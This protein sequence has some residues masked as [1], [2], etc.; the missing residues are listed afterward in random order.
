MSTGGRQIE[1]L[2]P[3]LQVVRAVLESN[4]WSLSGVQKTTSYEYEGPWE[5]QT[6]RSAYAFFHRVGTPEEGPSIEVFIDESD[7]GV[8]GALSLVVEGPA[9]ERESDVRAVLVGAVETAGEA[10]PS[11][12][13]APVSISYGHPGRRPPEAARVKVR[14]KAKLP[15]PAVKGGERTVRATLATILEAFEHVLD[16]RSDAGKDPTKE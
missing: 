2:E 12:L 15:R 9:V 13:P 8:D 4:R 6:L 10:L 16:V 3:L 7:E 14:F 1:T 11:E 5:G